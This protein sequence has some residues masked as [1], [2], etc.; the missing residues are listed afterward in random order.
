MAETRLII[1]VHES[2]SRF[3]KTGWHTRNVSLGFFVVGGH[4]GEQVHEFPQQRDQAHLAVFWLDNAFA[5]SR[6]RSI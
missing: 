1:Q 2:R 6:D 4:D 5:G 3:H